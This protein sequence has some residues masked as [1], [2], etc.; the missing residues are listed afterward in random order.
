MREIAIL[1]L[2]KLERRLM[3]THE[4]EATFSAELL[5][6]LVRRCTDADTGARN[7]DHT[8]RASL[9]PALAKSL[10]EFM[11][12]GEVPPKL[13]IGLSPEGNWRFDFTD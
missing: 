12:D 10:L 4:V 3:E 8:L 7:V 2:R 13:E 9:M 6:E 1:K 11:A 5:D